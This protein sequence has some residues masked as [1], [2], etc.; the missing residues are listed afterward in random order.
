MP[1][2]CCY[3][4]ANRRQTI[5]LLETQVNFAYSSKNTQVFDND[6]GIYNKMLH[7]NNIKKAKYQGTDITM[8]MFITYSFIFQQKITFKPNTHYID[9]YKYIFDCYALKSIC[10][11]HVKK[12]A[13]TMPKNYLKTDQIHIKIIF[14][15]VLYVLMEKKGVPEWL[16]HG[17]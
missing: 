4:T 12:M 8:S 9:V 6:V 5:G 3:V 14:N 15:S 11:A 17:M 13:R 2:D 1:F 16:K 10:W 7:T